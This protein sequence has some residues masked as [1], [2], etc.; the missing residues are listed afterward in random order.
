[1]FIVC[2]SEWAR[3]EGHAIPLAASKQQQ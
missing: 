1:L 3:L 2:Q